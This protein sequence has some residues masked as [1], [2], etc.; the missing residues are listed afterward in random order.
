MQ[1]PALSIVG[2]WQHGFASRSS[3][4]HQWISI[5]KQVLQYHRLCFYPRFSIRPIGFAVQRTLDMNRFQIFNHHSM[6]FI[7]NET[8]ETHVKS[9]SRRTQKEKEPFVSPSTHNQQ[10]DSIENG[11]IF[12]ESPKRFTVTEGRI[13]SRQSPRQRCS[14]ETKQN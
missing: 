7:N 4:L 12:G 10:I 11:K 5:L 2:S 13:Q 9:N 6:E 1:T 3:A 14:I 8:M